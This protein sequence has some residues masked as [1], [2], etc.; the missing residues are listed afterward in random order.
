MKSKKITS[1]ELEQEGHILHKLL[2]A[3]RQSLKKLQHQYPYSIPV[4]KKTR[5][6]HD[7]IQDINCVVFL[8]YIWFGY[9]NLV[10]QTS[11]FTGVIL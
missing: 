9:S 11:G 6:G 10:N 3:K 5:F 2:P 7:I 1:Q 8:V 4:V